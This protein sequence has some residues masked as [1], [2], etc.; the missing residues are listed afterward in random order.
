MVAVGRVQ[1]DHIYLLAPNKPINGYVCESDVSFHVILLNTVEF[2]YVFDE[3]LIFIILCRFFPI[4]SADNEK[5][6]ELQVSLVLESLMGMF[7][8]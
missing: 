6:G 3:L 2:A 8:M 5:V 7:Q 4:M 1:V